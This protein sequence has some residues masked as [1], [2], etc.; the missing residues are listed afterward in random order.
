MKKMNNP[1]E[2]PTEIDFEHLLSLADEAYKL[3]TGRSL[4]YFPAYNYETKSNT[5]GWK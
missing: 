2:M 5:D 3:K 1:A 4:D